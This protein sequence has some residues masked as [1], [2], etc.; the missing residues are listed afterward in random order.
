[1]LEHV[2]LA[3]KTALNNIRFQSVLRRLLENPFCSLAEA[4]Q[5]CGYYD[6]SYFTKVFKEYMGTTPAAFV[7]QIQ[8]MVRKGEPVKK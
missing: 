2:G 5:A 7:K 1:M 4:A 6:Q 8:E 3:P